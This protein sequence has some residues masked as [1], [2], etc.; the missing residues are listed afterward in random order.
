VRTSRSQV[1]AV[2]DGVAWLT[3]PREH[4]D[5]AAA[6]A[7][8]DAVE[9]IGFDES[10]RVAVVQGGRRAF[11]R[12]VGARGE[13]E[14]RQDWVA[15]VGALTVPVVAALG[16]DAIAEGAE[17]ALACDLRIAGH[18]AGLAFPQVLR[19]QLPCHGATQ[20]L[21]RLIG[22]QR[23]LDLLLSG[24]RV[25][26]REAERI[27]LVSQVVAA[28][29]LGLAVRHLV[30][31]LSAKAPVAL[32]LAKEAVLKGADLTFDQ[33]VRLEQDLY[34]LLQTTADRAEGIRAFLTKRSPKFRGA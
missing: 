34:V 33:G 14:T 1:L 27:G 28:G 20:R 23:A 10:V 16:G 12:G 24:R 22:R 32:R 21:P 8:C 26:A 6:Q 18:S 9:Q 15:A 5:Q 17:L 7:L 11:C 25:G 4:I 13:W 30:G 31:A 3:L 2:V 29:R 19:G